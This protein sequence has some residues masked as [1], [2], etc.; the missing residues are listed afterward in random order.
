MP[1]AWLVVPSTGHT[2][3]INEGCTAVV[4]GEDLVVFGGYTEGEEEAEEDGSTAA[5][6]TD[7]PAADEETEEGEEEEDGP[8][9]GQ[10]YHYHIPTAAW[11]TTRP[12]G[13]VNLEG[14]AAFCV[15]GTMLVFGGMDS[16]YSYSN[17]TYS[18]DFASELWSLADC[19]GDVPCPRYRFAAALTHDACRLYV[20]GGQGE[21]GVLS[22]LHVLDVQAQ[23]WERL[24]ND[25]SAGE[26]PE[27]RFLATLSHC[28]DRLLLFG[29]A[30]YAGGQELVSLGDLWAYDFAA[31][32]WQH[33]DLPGPSPRNG[34]CAVSDG[35]CVWVMGG[36]HH[37]AY[38][39][40]LWVLSEEEGA[41]IT[42]EGD[43]ALG[44]WRWKA[45]ACAGAVP[46]R[47]YMGAMALTADRRLLFIGGQKRHGGTTDV[48]QLPLGGPAPAG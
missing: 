12:A 35:H 21:A 8:L 13:C 42:V 40:D 18:Y 15:D 24:S 2:P 11:T 41:E 34:H 39:D 38:E 27:G 22:D 37:D 25:S 17:K 47:R 3:L 46:R 10:L 23:R 6:C 19:A 9:P 26:L 20:F 29:G 4:H 48:V 28:R 5:Q 44:R 31:A 45:V 33:V 7:A 43:P 14:H 32:R 30:K 1:V 16:T 36:G